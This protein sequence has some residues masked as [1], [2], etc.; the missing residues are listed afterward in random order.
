EYGGV[1]LLGVDGVSIIGHGR[2]SPKAIKNMILKAE[3]IVKLKINETIKE[4]I[5]DI[6]KLIPKTSLSEV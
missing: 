4:K 1:P 5:K 3:Q 2:S 6:K